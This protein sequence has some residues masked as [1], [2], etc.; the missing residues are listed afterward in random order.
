MCCN[1]DKIILMTFLNSVKI[2]VSV[3][4]LVPGPT[5]ALFTSNSISYEDGFVNTPDSSAVLNSLNTFPSFN[6]FFTILISTEIG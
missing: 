3:L 5:E 2:E 4:N 1:P 6:E